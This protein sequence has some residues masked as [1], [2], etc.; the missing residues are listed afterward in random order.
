MR[1][2]YLIVGGG[3]V[4]DAAARGIR[5]NDTSGTIGILGADSDEPY[6]RPALSKKLW[7][8]KDFGRDQVPLNTASDTGAEV[9]T[10]TRVRS[11]DRGNKT[12][13]TESE[14]AFEYGDLL[15]A[16][17]ASPVQLGIAPSP[18]VIYFRT[19]A[20]YRALRDLTKTASHIAIVGGGYIGTEIA[21]ALALNGVAVTLITS[22][23]VVGGHMFPA[24]L[25]AAFEAGFSEHGVTIRRAVK[26][27]TAAEASA[28]VQLQLD[29]G[30]SVEADGVVFGLGVRPNVDLAEASGL[31]V[32]NGIVVDEYLRTD[33]RHIYAAGDVAN[34]PDAILGRRRI[35]HVDNAI[36]MGKAVGRIMAGG[37]EPYT[38]TPYFYS[39]VFDDGYQAVGTI[40]TSLRTVEE[41]KVEPKEGVIYYLEGD[42][43]RGVLMWNVWEGLDEAKALLGKKKAGRP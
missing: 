25:A 22:D 37:T 27:T 30:S 3:M 28:R 8:D 5:E 23:D 41:W 15:L 16:T 2:D 33:D 43:V 31:A 11:V 13:T 17:G 42:K 40:D 14:D 9:R 18:R 20:D 6:T 39:D 26:V 32:D 10:N 21:S 4:A 7:T 19:F 38:Y 35:E 12:V 24:S 34:Y 1:Y 29:D 36:E